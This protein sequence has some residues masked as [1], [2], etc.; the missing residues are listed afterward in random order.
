MVI[1]M[2]LEEEGYQVDAVSSTKD[3]IATSTSTR[4]PASTFSPRRA[5]ATP[6]AP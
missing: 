2:A 3:A 4:R 1:S 6:I 5:A